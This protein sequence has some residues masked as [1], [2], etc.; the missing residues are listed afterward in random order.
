MR[1][2]KPLLAVSSLALCIAAMSGAAKA[3]GV[4]A[5]TL[6]QNTA[7]ATYKTGTSTGNV[8]SNTVSVKVDQ[9]LDVAVAGLNSSPVAAASTAAVLTYSVTNTGNGTDSFN[10]TADPAVSGNSF[11]GVIQGVYV[12]S[13]GD[14][15]YTPGADTLVATDGPSSA[16]AEDGSVKVFVI[17][18]LPAGATDAQASQVKLTATS[19]IGSGTPGTV[20]AGKGQGG[21][22]AV[23]G[24]SHATQSALDSIIASLA[25]VSLVK[26]AAIV[27][28]FGGSSPV[29]GATV[30]YS[31]VAHV[32]G[33]GTAEG[34]HVTDIIPTNTAYQ[35]GTLTL[36]GTALSDAVDGDA[37]TAS[38]SG[39]DVALGN[40]VGGASDKTVSFKVKIN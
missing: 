11:N 6:I 31:I 27:D 28:Q 22:D 2:T 34:L 10:L 33:S 29:P 35:V 21:S 37:G 12:D 32:T 40:L 8:Q 14:G 36:N 38:A 23:V 1:N 25:T 39:I 7:T 30:T 18:S 4:A 13:N 26:T 9:L 20:F 24:S 19:V 3:A 15:V 17:V 16:I 5:G